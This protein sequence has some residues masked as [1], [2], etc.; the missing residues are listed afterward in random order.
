[1]KKITTLTMIIAINILFVSILSAQT[2]PEPP[3]KGNGSKASPYEIHTLE[4]LKWL[5][6]TPYLLGYDYLYFVQTADI[7]AAE[8]DSLSWNYGAGFMPIGRL[9][10]NF[11]GSYDGKNHSISNLKIAT[12]SGS[13][14]NYYGLFGMVNESEIKDLHLINVKR[15]G[16][17]EYDFKVGTLAGRV[18]NSK[19]T[20]VSVTNTNEIQLG[21]TGGLIGV[22]NNSLINK[23]KATSWQSSH[24]EIRPNQ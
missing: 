19:V 22:T 12:Y 18:D 20:N 4:N 16:N 23:C 9:S 21:M 3:S 24:S 10:R 14:G 5:S 2:K 11:R 6:E 7:D 1:M 17:T 15:T 13:L 8:T